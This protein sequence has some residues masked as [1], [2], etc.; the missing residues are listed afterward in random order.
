MSFLG[1]VKRSD[2][3]EMAEEETWGS[4]RPSGFTGTCTTN[5]VMDGSQNS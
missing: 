5:G 2:L 1:S 3:L 4:G